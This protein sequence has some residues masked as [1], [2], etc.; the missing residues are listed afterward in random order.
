MMKSTDFTLELV[1]WVREALIKDEKNFRQQSSG[2]DINPQT[3]EIEGRRNPVEFDAEPDKN[4]AIEQKDVERKIRVLDDDEN[5]KA[6][7]PDEKGDAS[8]AAPAGLEIQLGYGSGT[9]QGPLVTGGFRDE[10][11]GEVEELEEDDKDSPFV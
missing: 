10:E 1:K 8:Q 6:N 9:E 11:R 4:A 5:I 2:E 7:K 3:K